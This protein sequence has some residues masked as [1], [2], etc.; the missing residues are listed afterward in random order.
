MTLDRLI[1][2]KDDEEIIFSLRRHPIS[3]LGD[4]AMIVVVALVPVGV[5]ILS[6]DLWPQLL[7]GPLTRPTIVLAMSAYYLVVWLFFI[8]TFVDYYL[9]I[10]IVTTYRVVSVEQHSLFSRTISELDLAKVQD[11]TSEVKGVIPSV[12]NYGNVHV[13]TAAEKE[14]FVFE[15]IPR[16]HD[17][18]KRLLDLV[19]DDRKRQLAPITDRMN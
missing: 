14:R 2:P 7:A 12:L 3:L 18:R 11:V 4:F 1:N 6:G 5:M 13:Q 9:D 17:V 15:Q 10:W 19:E 8:T 16:A